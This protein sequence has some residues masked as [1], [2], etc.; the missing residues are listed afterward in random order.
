MFYAFSPQ[1]GMNFYYYLRA[2]FYSPFFPLKKI[3]APRF[4]QLFKGY[5]RSINLPSLGFFAASSHNT[6]SHGMAAS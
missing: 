3:T 6:H 4:E 5:P 1:K 2:I